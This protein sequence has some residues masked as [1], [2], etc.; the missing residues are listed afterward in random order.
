MRYLRLTAVV[1][2][3]AVLA[4]CS[5]P[6]RTSEEMAAASPEARLQ[7]IPPADPQKYGQAPGFKEWRNPYLI[8]RKDGVALLDTQNSEEHLIKLEDLPQTLAQLPRSAWPYGRVVAVIEPGVRASGDDALIR[9]N[10]GI[11]LGTLESMH[12]LVSIGPPP[13]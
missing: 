9:K 11:V 8:I 10:R 1:M 4:C 7:Q 5:K 13:A 6:P 3:A 12:V 2:C